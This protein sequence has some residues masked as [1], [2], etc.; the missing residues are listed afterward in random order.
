M[1][2]FFSQVDFNWADPQGL[3]R[4]LCEA[5]TKEGFEVEEIAYVA[6]SDAHLLEANRKYLNHDYYTD[7]IT[8]DYGWDRQLKADVLISVERV[9][10]NAQT[11]G[12]AF[13][14]ELHRVVIHAALHLMGYDDKSEAE[15]QRMRRREDFYLARLT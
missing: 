10:E 4:W 2:S 15:Q 1:I 13:Y 12:V 6:C 7:V 5:V 9:R 11:Y 8:F 3:S 14:K